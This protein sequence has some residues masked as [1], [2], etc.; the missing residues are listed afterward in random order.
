MTRCKRGEQEWLNTT[1]LAFRMCAGMNLG[2]QIS[3]RQ[4]KSRVDTHNSIHVQVQIV[5]FHVV[6]VGQCDVDRNDDLV[7]VFAFDLCLVLLDDWTD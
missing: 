7:T 2:G 1:D 3:G 4:A 6:G 5:E